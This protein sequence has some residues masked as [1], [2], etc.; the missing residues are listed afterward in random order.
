M[1]ADS[2]TVFMTVTLPLIKDSF[3]SGSER[4]LSAPSHRNFCSYPLG[5]TRVPAHHRS[6]NEF[7]GRV[8]GMALRFCNN[9]DCYY[10]WLGIA[11]ELGHQTLWHQP[12]TQEGNTWLQR[13]KAFALSISKD[14]SGSR[15]ER[16]LRSSRR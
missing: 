10:P 9:S 11:Y 8:H 14:L 2:F 13:K 12:S 15:L 5:H 7:A 1:G 16:L 4:R 6:D 3:S